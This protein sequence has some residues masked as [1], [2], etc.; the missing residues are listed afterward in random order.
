MDRVNN[1]GK[2]Y[3]FAKSFVIPMQIMFQISICG[4]F[5]AKG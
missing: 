1:V 3:Y 2:F 4:I 5:G